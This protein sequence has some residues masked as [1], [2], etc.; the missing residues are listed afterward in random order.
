AFKRSQFGSMWKPRRKR[1]RNP[2][3]S[4]RSQTTSYLV[5]VFLPSGYTMCGVPMRTRYSTWPDICLPRQQRRCSTLRLADRQ[6]ALCS[7][8]SLSLPRSCTKWPNRNP[9]RGPPRMNSSTQTRRD[10]FV[11]SRARK[12]LSEPLTPRGRNGLL[13][14]I[15]LNA[16]WWNGNTTVR[17]VSRD[18]RVQERRSLLSTGLCIW[19]EATANRACFSQLFPNL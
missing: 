7:R 18:P 17:L 13:F 4:L 8:Q 1:S 2:P 16:N 15:R 10:A 19:H 6:R 14:Y 12:S 5:L 9:N 11:P 3:C